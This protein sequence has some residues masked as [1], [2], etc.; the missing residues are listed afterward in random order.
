MTKKKLRTKN[1]TVVKNTLQDDK[2][3]EQK[4]EVEEDIID[5]SINFFKNLFIQKPA[6]KSDK[7]N[8]TKI[9]I[10]KKAIGYTILA[11]FILFIMISIFWLNVQRQIKFNQKP[12]LITA[13]QPQYKGQIGM[14]VYYDHQFIVDNNAR[15]IQIH[16]KL[17]GTLLDVISFDFVPVGVAELFSGILLVRAEN[18]DVLYFYENKKL[19]KTLTLPGFSLA[20]NFNTDSKDNIYYSNISDG[21]IF[22]YSSDG[23]KLLEF[24]GFGKTKDKFVKPGKLFL[25]KNDNLYIY[26]LSSPAKIKIFSS[27]G[28]FIKEIDTKMNRLRGWEGIAVT[29]DGNI[30]IN[31]L[32]ENCIRVYSG[33]NGKLLGKFTNDAS[34]K[35]GIGIPNCLSGGI[36]NIIYVHTQA[37][38][39]INY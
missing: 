32:F 1:K 10:N 12:E 18:S 8:Q 23:Q 3:I 38:K 15:E 31:D 33:K 11:L 25:D 27:E 20:P 7:K 5:I 16:K 2:T 4:Q 37:F 29:H 21:K 34:G 39:P 26:D 35:V 9:Y 22:K 24:G 17:E 36:D 6:E 28:K 19:I 14:P 13:W 30:Y